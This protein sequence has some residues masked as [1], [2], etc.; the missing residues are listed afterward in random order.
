MAVEIAQTMLSGNTGKGGA[1]FA[2]DTPQKCRAAKIRAALERLF[3]KSP[4][5]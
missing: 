5:N 3:H 4:F 1:V 2:S